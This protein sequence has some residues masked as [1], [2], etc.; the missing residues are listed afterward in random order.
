[1]FATGLIRSLQATA[2]SLKMFFPHDE[3]SAVFTGD[4]NNAED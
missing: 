1:M 2:P 4:L 3:Q